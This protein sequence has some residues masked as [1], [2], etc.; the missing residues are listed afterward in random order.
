MCRRLLTTHADPSQ[1][2]CDCGSYNWR[3]LHVI[4]PAHAA[5]RKKG[6]GRAHILRRAQ[7]WDPLDVKVATDCAD[8]ARSSAMSRIVYATIGVQY[9]H[10]FQLPGLMQ[11]PSNAVPPSPFITPPGMS[12][13]GGLN[14]PA[15][16]S[17]G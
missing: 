14:S 16:N 1:C 2:R 9:S 17:F 4:A 6:A 8:Y 11:I 12:G 15:L 7:A 13:V 5:T 3:W 10:V